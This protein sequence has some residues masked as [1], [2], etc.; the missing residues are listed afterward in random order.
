MGY[1]FNPFTGN[2]DY[3]T[4]TVYTP[5]VTTLHSIVSAAPT[6]GTIAFATDVGRFLIADGTNWK[7]ASPLLSTRGSGEDIGVEKHSSLDGYASDYITDKDLHNVVLK[8]SVTEEEGSIR[9]NAGTFQ[10]Y[11]NSQWNDVVINFVL[12]EDSSEWYALEHKPVVPGAAKWSILYSGNSH[13]TGID[14]LPLVQQYIASMGA[15]QV[16]LIVKG[17]SF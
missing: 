5:L 8:Y 10:V 17:R 4:N 12:Q 6:Q 9:T 11:L 16:P 13:E 7:E 15:Q 2:L 14:G 3:D 1:V